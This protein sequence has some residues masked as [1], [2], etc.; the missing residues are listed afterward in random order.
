MTIT[1][2][3]GRDRRAADDRRRHRRIADGASAVLTPDAVERID[4]SRAVVDELVGGE[5]LIYGLNTGL[6]HMRDVRMP[7]ETLGA[8]Q[9]A[10][11]VGHDGA[12]GEPLCETGRAS[13][14]GRPPRRDRPGRQ[15]GESRRRRDAR[16]DARSRR[17]PDRAGDRLGRRVAT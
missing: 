14:D 2:D 9:E 5:E 15:R 3:R 4:A 1:A 10:I 7:L 13:R 6:G 16:R 8:Y 11:V 17:P 12:I